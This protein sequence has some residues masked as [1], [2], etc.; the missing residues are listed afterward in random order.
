MIFKQ[1]NTCPRL[2]FMVFY[3]V[4]TSWVKTV[5][6]HTM[7]K[8]F[9][10]KP[11]SEV[12]ASVRPKYSI[13]NHCLKGKPQTQKC[14]SWGMCVCRQASGRGEE[15]S[16]CFWFSSF[17]GKR[18]FYTKILTN[19]LWN[20]S[21]KYTPQRRKMSLNSLKKIS[22]LELPGKFA[23]YTQLLCK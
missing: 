7:E 1:R 21:Q 11:S 10:Q 20:L 13:I 19:I 8:V 5:T 12:L 15:R 23:L 17:S 9:N 2:W 14:F 22:S 4:W 18:F 16:L 6:S 3:T